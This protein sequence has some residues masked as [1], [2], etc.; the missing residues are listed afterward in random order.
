MLKLEDA[1]L[2]SIQKAAM[3]RFNSPLLLAKHAPEHLNPGSASSITLTTGS[4]SR[5]PMKDCSTGASYATGLHGMMRNLA[6]DLA[7]VR[8]NLISPGAVLT[9]LWDSLDKDRRESLMENMKGK[10]TT[11]EI[12]RSEDVAESYLYVMRDWN[13][14][15]SVIDTNGGSLLTS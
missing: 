15:G 5:K 13:V 7:P 2:E 4:V 1:T 8:V 6:L 10:C 3:V 14:S 11:G 12:G 9:P